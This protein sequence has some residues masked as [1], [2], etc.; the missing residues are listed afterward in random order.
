MS[1]VG[2][3]RPN[4]TITFTIFNDDGVVGQR[5]TVLQVPCTYYRLKVETSGGNSHGCQG[6]I[7]SIKR[8]DV[9]VF[10]G[11][12]AILT[13][14]PAEKPDSLSKTI[15]QGDAEHLDMLAITD[16]NQVIITSQGFSGAS[17]VNW[18]DMFAKA[19]NYI[20]EI[21]IV[22]SERYYGERQRA[23]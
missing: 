21:V 12:K 6:R 4:T 18:N 22:S 19:G 7:V 11:E 9:P 15:Y 20:F 8:G 1:D 5:K 16:R 14:V 17:S 23:A 10:A 13:F 2:C 3:H